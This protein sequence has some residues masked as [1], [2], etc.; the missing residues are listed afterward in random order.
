VNGTEAPEFGLGECQGSVS[1]RRRRPAGGPKLGSG[2]RGG[3]SDFY[4]PRETTAR[5][6]SRDHGR[7]E[8]SDKIQLETGLVD[9]RKSSREEPLEN[10]PEVEPRKKRRYRRAKCL[11]FM[12]KREAGARGDFR[13]QKSLIIRHAGKSYPKSDFYDS[14]GKRLQCIETLSGG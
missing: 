13:G 4:A 7:G 12:E 1:N 10:R 5:I 9:G 6:R 14:T 3:S 2:C 11:Y 8:I